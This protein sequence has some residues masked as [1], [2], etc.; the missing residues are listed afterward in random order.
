M[1]KKERKKIG[2]R[3]CKE[4]KRKLDVENAEKE[5]GEN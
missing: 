3:E 5:K 4:K 1:N 2:S